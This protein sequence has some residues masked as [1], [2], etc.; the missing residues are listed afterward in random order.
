M[1]Q[2]KLARLLKL[3][4]VN[5]MEDGGNAH[6]Q[7]KR[8]ERDVTKQAALGLLRSWRHA[9]GNGRGLSAAPRRPRGPA[10]R[11]NAASRTRQ[12]PAALGTH[13]P[14]PRGTQVLR[15]GKNTRPTIHYVLVTRWTGERWFTTCLGSLRCS[16]K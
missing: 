8:R 13:R 7:W 9:R 5:H 15:R 2:A 11:Y 1:C 16:S 10:R 4:H 6:T 14:G 12:S 3:H